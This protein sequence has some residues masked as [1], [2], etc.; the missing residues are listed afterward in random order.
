MVVPSGVVLL[1]PADQPD[2]DVRVPVEGGVDTFVV[3][4]GEVVLPQVRPAR[5]AGGQLAE[6]GLAQVTIGEVLEVEAGAQ[7]GDPL[8]SR[9][10]YLRLGVDAEHDLGRHA[11]TSRRPW[12]G[13]ATPSS[14]SGVLA[15]DPLRRRL[16]ELRVRQERKAGRCPGR[17]C[18][19]RAP[20]PGRR[21]P[22]ARTTRCRRTARGR[23]RRYRRRPGPCI[24]PDGVERVRHRR[25]RPLA[26]G[27]SVPAR[28]P[29]ARPTRPPAAA[30]CSPRPPPTR[31]AGPRRTHLRGPVP[32]ARGPAGRRLGGCEHRPCGQPSLGRRQQGGRQL[33]ADEAGGEPGPEPV[34][35]RRHGGHRGP[36]AES[37]GERRR[38]FVPDIEQRTR[39]FRR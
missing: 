33:Q 34:D 20:A 5:E 26:T 35:V 13:S 9:S 37:L 18:R 22:S 3:V 6:L 38:A 16:A 21:S 15:P 4:E 1:G 27:G 28:R 36:C 31:P 10:G 2:V 19:C 32:G 23:R 25:R 24:A 11:A 17:R 39:L 7:R 14:R 12:A 8:G 30:P 29:R